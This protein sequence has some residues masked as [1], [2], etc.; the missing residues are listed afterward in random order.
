MTIFERIDTRIPLP[1][2]VLTVGTFDGV[3]LGHQAILK[4]VRHEAR[5]RSGSAV[6]LTFDRHPKAVL[7]PGSAPLAL[8]G[9]REKRDVLRATG[10]DGLIELPFT[11]DLAGTSPEEFV[12]RVIVRGVGAVVVVMGHDHRFGRGR[13]GD[14]STVRSIGKQ[15]GLEV[16]RVDPTVVDGV[17]VS[18]TR[19]RD[20]VSSGA[21]AEATRLLGRPYGLVGE[22]V[23]GDGRGHRIGFPTANIVPEVPQKLLPPD[24]V[25]VV[26]VADGQSLRGG[27]CNIGTRPTFGGQGRRVEAH[28]LDF[29]G[30][31]Y[32]RTLAV[33][34]LSRIRE[35]R[36]F[37]SPE[38]LLG[39]IKKDIGAARQRLGEFAED[40]GRHPLRTKIA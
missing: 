5:R 40:A 35:E 33:H 15:F 31:L 37:D 20:L 21:V 27:V 36:R 29:E 10:I 28:L 23:E 18:S 16:I 22:V 34:F 17:V 4:V 9:P 8:L 25:Y 7:S 2:P 13:S 38:S 24:G 12:D 32:G 30:D 14:F 6:V 1:A 11:E 39:Q 3:H 19:V 26:Q